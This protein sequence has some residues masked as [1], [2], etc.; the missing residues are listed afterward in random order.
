VNIIVVYTSD[1]VIRE[2]AELL[3]KSIA[4]NLIR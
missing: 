2:E 3:S 1:P 4:S